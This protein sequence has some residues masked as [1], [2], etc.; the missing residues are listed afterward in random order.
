MISTI[1]TEAVLLFIIFLWI[2]SVTFRLGMRFSDRKI[3]AFRKTI[4]TYEG[5]LTAIFDVRKEVKKEKRYLEDKLT[6]LS[7]LYAITK[8]MSSKMRFQDLMNIL[9]NF[10]EDNFFFSK[11]QIVIL[12][13]EGK[14]NTVYEIGKEYK[15]DVKLDAFLQDLTSS[16][17]KSRKHSF[18]ESSNDLF[19]F[20][21]HE[22]VIN[23]L[24]IPLVVRKDTVA[25][26][27]IENI[28]KEEIDTFLILAGQVTL[29]IERIRLFASVEKLSIT[30]G[31]TKTYLRRYFTERLEV[32]T[33][34]SKEYG[35]ELSFIMIDL[36]YFKKCNDKF[37]HLVGDTVLR[38]TADILKHNLREI[39]IVARY[40]GEEFCALLPETDKDGALIVAERIRKSVEEH[41][42]NAYDESVNITVS[43]GVTSFVKE[44]NDSA[45]ELVERADK[46]LYEA[47]NLGR[48]KVC[49]A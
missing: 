34:R 39:D 41:T 37:G 24:A 5:R 4:S 13:K 18:L 35:S 19:K 11:F 42:I 3:G 31:L 21:L 29:Q 47:K 10:I 46:A 38:E 1:N 36:D 30:D 17:A 12:D 15:K 23:I 45:K 49:M 20:G 22:N 48:N 7:R 27:L 44:G 6:Y 16:S 43:I 2:L 28:K 40:G 14:T 33:L 26:F 9:K 25:V 8:N 32:E